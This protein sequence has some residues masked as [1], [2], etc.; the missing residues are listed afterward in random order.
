M[1]ICGGQGK[2]KYPAMSPQLWAHNE[3]YRHLVLAEVVVQRR[4]AY[5]RISV[6]CVR[7]MHI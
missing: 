7:V 4:Y 3:K 2:V 6:S 5:Y 1:E